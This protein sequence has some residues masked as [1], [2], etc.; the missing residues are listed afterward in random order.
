MNSPSPPVQQLGAA[1]LLQGQAVVDAYYLVS[2]G[3]RA[4]ARNGYPTSRFEAIQTAIQSAFMSSRRHDD[5]ASVALQSHSNR[6]DEC[7][8]DPIGTAEAA[9]LLG[10][11]VRSCQRLA[12]QGLGRR[13]GHQWVLDRGLVIAEAQR[14]KDQQP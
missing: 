13:V 11:S 5:V 10:L 4:A 8:V 1:V 9:A 14:R 7:P 6:D 3:I 2:T 12:K